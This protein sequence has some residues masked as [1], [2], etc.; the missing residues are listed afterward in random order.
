ML[1]LLFIAAAVGCLWLLVPLDLEIQQILPSVVNFLN[2][3]R[4]G[5]ELPNATVAAAYPWLQESGGHDPIQG[6]FYMGVREWVC[7]FSLA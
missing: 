6:G 3:Q 4:S 1:C 7:L 2:A 5:G